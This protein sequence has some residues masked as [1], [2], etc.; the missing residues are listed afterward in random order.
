[1][2]KLGL[3]LLAQSV[4]SRAALTGCRKPN[5]ILSAGAHTKYVPLE[6]MPNPPKAPDPEH[7]SN[8][9]W[10]KVVQSDLKTSDHCLYWDTRAPTKK[11]LAWADAF[12][13]STEHTSRRLHP[14][15]AY[16]Q[17]EKPTVPEIVL[18]SGSNGEKRL[19]LNWIFE[20]YLATSKAVPGRKFKLVP[21]A[22]GWKESRGFKAIIVDTPGLSSKN[23][24]ERAQMFARYM[25]NKREPYVFLTINAEQ[26][27]KMQDLECLDRLRRFRIPH[28][29]VLNRADYV[30]RGSWEGKIVPESQGCEEGFR[31]LKKRIKELKDI[32]KPP[33]MKEGQIAGKGEIIAYGATQHGAFGISH[34]RWAILQAAGLDRLY[35]SKASKEKDLKVSKEKG[36]KASKEKDS[37]VSK[38]KGF[39]M[40]QRRIRKPPIQS[41]L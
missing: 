26:G 23:S 39:G 25:I 41:R 19:T 35:E 15:R 16:H 29:V 8:F 17:L 36:L 20:Q 18:M 5:L 12:F 30:L 9:E 4:W 10:D 6:P 24:D 22:I 40:N 28:Q 33:D 32:V 38:E 27:P 21:Y 37:K 14:S 2:S 3:T 31:N 34:L 13:R 11:Q 7:F 1:M